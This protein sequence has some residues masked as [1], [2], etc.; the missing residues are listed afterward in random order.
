MMTLT[1]LVVGHL[2]VDTR[3]FYPKA[4]E[5]TAIEAPVLMW[6]LRDGDRTLVF[7]TGGSDVAHAHR[8]GH[9]HYQRTRQEEPLEKL[10]AI[11]VRP[12]DVN[13]VVLS[14][15]HWDHASNWQLFE[16]A[17]VWVGARD[18]SYAAHPDSGHEVYFDFC[19]GPAPY[20]D[21]DRFHAVDGERALS[22]DGAVRIVP[23][24]GHTPGS[25]GLLV[26]SAVG[27]V[28]LPGDA[29]PLLHNLA[30][31]PPTPNGIAVDS[32]ALQRTLNDLAPEWTV[33]PSHDPSLEPF[34]QEN[35]LSSACW[36]D[37][38]FQWR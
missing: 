29:V 1:P 9:G 32:V 13:T 8:M 11:G 35:I 21:P 22:Q 12:Q 15:L 30:D 24:P 16:R 37:G 17:T 14:H 27:T 38:A 4:P 6:V 20:W 2:S 33:F 18:I 36:K 10:T 26:A 23:L 3:T 7:D 25:Q 31:T 28:L 34:D 5:H 19:G